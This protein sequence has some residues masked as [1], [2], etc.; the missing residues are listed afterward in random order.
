MDRAEAERLRILAFWAILGLALGVGALV[1]HV[2]LDR[3]A[4]CGFNDEMQAFRVSLVLIVIGPYIGCIALPVL[5]R[6]PPEK[7]IR[8]TFLLGF[9]SSV[10]TGIAFSSSTDYDVGVGDYLTFLLPL[11]GLIA[12][13]RG[14]TKPGRIGGYVLGAATVPALFFILF[15][16][17]D[18]CS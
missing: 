8:A 12:V 1:W 13:W 11:V 4:R 9:A 10:L 7:R 15:A 5:W 16:V 2:S 6:R 18:T 3:F 14:G 17:A